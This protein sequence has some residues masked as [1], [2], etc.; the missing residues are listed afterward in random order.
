M[1]EGYCVSDIMSEKPE[2]FNGSVEIAGQGNNSALYELIGSF[3]SNKRYIIE[4]HTFEMSDMYIVRVDEEIYK[5]IDGET[6][7]GE[8]VTKVEWEPYSLF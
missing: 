7:K 5:I 4:H 8:K 2:S 6:F 3:S 1:P